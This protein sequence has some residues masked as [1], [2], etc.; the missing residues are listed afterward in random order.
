MNNRIS[1]I[2]VSL[3][4]LAVFVLPAALKA[5]PEKLEYLELG[6]L[7]LREL[8]PGTLTIYKQVRIHNGYV[9][10]RFRIAADSGRFD[11][12]G[13][14]GTTIL[15]GRIHDLS[16]EGY[17]YFSNEDQIGSMI[18]ERQDQLKF[19][20]EPET[21]TLP[22]YGGGTIQLE[23][24]RV[25]V[26]NQTVIDLLAN[27]GSV[28][29]ST[30]SV[31]WNDIHVATE[32]PKASF[33][34]NAR[35]LGVSKG[36]RFVFDL[37]KAKLSLDEGT[38]QSI[39]CRGQDEAASAGDPGVRLNIANVTGPVRLAVQHDRVGISAAKLSL[40]LAAATSAGLS[41]TAVAA[42]GT[43]SFKAVSGQADWSLTQVLVRNLAADSIRFT[44]SVQAAA[45]NEAWNV[46]A[47]KGLF[48]GLQWSDPE[49]VH[50][51]A[52]K[53][54]QDSLATLGGEL[55]FA[56]IRR[57]LVEQIVQLQLKS[58]KQLALTRVTFG[59]QSI[60]VGA[61]L[62]TTVPFVSQSIK[63]PID[64]E[65]TVGVRGSALVLRPVIRMVMLGSFSIPQPATLSAVLATL[66]D[67]I[68]SILDHGE[69]GLVEIVVPVDLKPA[70]D[71]DLS[72]L[73]AGDLTITSSKYTLPVELRPTVL[74]SQDTMWIL[75]EAVTK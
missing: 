5:V 24:R 28:Y 42:L 48:T 38:F 29:F 22:T 3:T 59:L 45:G 72:R 32:A 19:I 1:R 55:A 64:V 50:A 43:V 6:A 67:K 34:M 39:T 53:E 35:S 18:V 47:L 40:D 30:D 13:Q 58:L 7:K 60:A 23:Q 2:I 10:H 9:H 25:W 37:A 20:L 62:Q 11:Y 46:P 61:E 27:S 54:A 51:L 71:V 57:S 68:G 21:Y 33:L 17:I 66:K 70:I 49:Q 69:A 16:I 8:R 31:A 26:G 63:F 4:M 14:E 41:K 65:L 75:S 15:G 12:T 56:S 74:I 44:P 73:S 36:V 52:I